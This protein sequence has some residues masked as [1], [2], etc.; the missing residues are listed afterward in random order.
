MLECFEKL[1]K[2]GMKYIILDLQDNGGGFLQAAVDV[3]NEFL[4]DGDLIVVAGQEI[5][6]AQ[7]RGAGADDGDL[8]VAVII[9]LLG[10][11]AGGAIQ[12]SVG[13]ELGV[14]LPTL[15]KVQFLSHRLNQVKALSV[16]DEDELLRVTFRRRLY[17]ATIVGTHF[18]VV[19]ATVHQKHLSRFRKTC[20]SPSGM[21]DEAA[22]QPYAQ[23]HD[24]LARME[25]NHVIHSNEILLTDKY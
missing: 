18:Q 4:E 22:N 3:L 6:A 13:D 20:L 1:R 21:T 7:A 8:F 2:Q 5:G 19:A 16:G 14:P 23:T 17:P 11:E 25:R 10:H 9:E 12:L 15:R 24:K